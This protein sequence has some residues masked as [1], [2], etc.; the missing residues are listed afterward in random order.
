MSAGRPAR[1]SLAAILAAAALAAGGT[2]A[3]ASA[4][5]L[6]PVADTLTTAHDRV[7]T[8]PAPGV[9][10]NDIGIG[11]GTQAD[12]DTPPP[13]GTD[14]NEPD[15]AYRNTPDPPYHGTER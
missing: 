8:V 10:A 12:H 7:A 4:I 5:S 13:N 3:P 15:G 11:G 1:A 2:S 6:L 9:L 14:D